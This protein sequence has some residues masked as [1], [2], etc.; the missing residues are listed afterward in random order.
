MQHMVS[1]QYSTGIGLRLV[2]GRGFDAV[3]AWWLQW[4]P[5]PRI[6]RRRQ[7]TIRAAQFSA[8]ITT[9]TF[10]SCNSARTRHR[11]I[12]ESMNR[13]GRHRRVEQIL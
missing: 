4:R 13:N 6:G 8:L 3:G 12:D 5:L 11:S 7:T 1:L 2:T 10:N 9:S